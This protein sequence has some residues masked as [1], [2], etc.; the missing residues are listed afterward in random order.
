MRLL[1]LNQ[2]Y[3]PDVAPTGRF[4]EDLALALVARGHEVHVICSRRSY[5]SPERYPREEERHR[6][7]V[8]RVAAL[9]LGRRGHVA[10]LLDY[11]SFM[12]LAGLRALRVPRPDL[13]LA[14]TT[15]PYVGVLAKLVASLRGG[16]HAHWIMDLYPDALVAH[17]MLRPTR[18]ASGGLRALTRWQLAGARAVICLGPFVAGRVAAYLAPGAKADVVALWAR[19]EPMPAKSVRADR[20]WSADELVLMYSGNMGLGHRFDEFLRAAAQLGPTGPRWAFVG[21]GPRRGEVEAFA[22]HHPEARVELLPYVDG[23]RLAASLTSADVHLVSLA[24]AWQG[25]IVPSKL[26]AVFALGRPVLFVGPRENEIAQ[27]IEESG[28]GWIVAEDDV[29]DLLAAVAQ[30]GHSGERRRRGEAALAFAGSHFDRAKNVERIVE[31]LESG[32]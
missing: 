27:W 31:R 2:Y 10:R 17:G 22:G 28:G 12:L 25:V 20:G 14:L 11:V 1:L 3:P 16:A 26:H 23:E 18:L 9:G 8:H 30:A 21:D 24:R 32:S 15:P 4:L 29:A 19:A 7:H 13:V 6:V 5:G